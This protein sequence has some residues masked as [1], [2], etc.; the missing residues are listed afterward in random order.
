MLGGI[1][2]KNVFRPIS[3]T[4]TT[5]GATP[6]LTPFALDRIA[7][8]ERDWKEN[9]RWR[10]IERRYTAEDVERIRGSLDIEHSLAKHGSDRLW[11]LL[12][13]RPFIRALGALTGNQAM[14]QVEQQES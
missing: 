5:P 8:T 10:G 3:T 7:R 13:T 1:L 9:P 14:Q 6:A 12:H 11:N 4:P 2:S